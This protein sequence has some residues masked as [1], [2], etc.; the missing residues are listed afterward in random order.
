MYNWKIDKEESK[1]LKT[2]QGQLYQSA[3]LKNTRRN[4]AYILCKLNKRKI[5]NLRNLYISYIKFGFL[6]IKVM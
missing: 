5:F 4:S 2:L 1:L 3:F 6:F